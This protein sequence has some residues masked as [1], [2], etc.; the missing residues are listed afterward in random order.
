MSFSEA[1]AYTETDVLDASD[2]KLDQYLDWY[3]TNMASEEIR[4]RGR[5]GRDVDFRRTLFR[6]FPLSGT[7]AA[8]EDLPN[9]SGEAEI[10]A[11]RLRQVQ[12]AL[13]PKKVIGPKHNAQKRTGSFYR[14]FRT[15]ADLDG[16]SKVIYERAAELAGLS[17]EAM[18]QAVFAIERKMQTFEER[19]RKGR[20]G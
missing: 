7:Q 10:P 9:V 19:T 20:D 3:E 6:L 4:E 16:V 5:A 11:D 18:I 13:Q 15:V 1:L 12:R 8:R 2:D 14:R 17:L